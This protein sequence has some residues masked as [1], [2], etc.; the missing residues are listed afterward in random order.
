VEMMI[1]K[2]Q[3]NVRKLK[4]VPPEL[5]VAKVDLLDELQ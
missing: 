2:K 3:N 5:A 1:K 4:V